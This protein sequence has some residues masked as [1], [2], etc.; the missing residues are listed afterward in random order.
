M[1]ENVRNGVGIERNRK[2]KN[3]ERRKRKGR[4]I[5]NRNRGGRGNDKKRINS[6]NVDENQKK[7]RGMKE[8]RVS[9]LLRGLPTISRYLVLT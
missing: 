5:E 1:S 9:N 2:I 6:V 8:S 7:E 3:G 4:E